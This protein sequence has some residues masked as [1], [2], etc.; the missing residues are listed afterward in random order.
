MDGISK[1]RLNLLHDLADVL[2]FAAELRREFDLGNAT[3]DKPP[4]GRNGN[5]PGGQ[6]R[7]LRFDDERE[8]LVIECK[9]ALPGFSIGIHSLDVMWFIRFSRRF[10]R[11]D[12]GQFVKVVEVVMHNFRELFAHDL[13]LW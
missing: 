11:N 12:A 13:M 7:I 6:S 2:F 9:E 3:S 5:A 8:H 10:I 1:F 4:T